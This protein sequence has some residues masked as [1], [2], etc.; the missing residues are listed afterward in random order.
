MDQLTVGKILMRVGELPALPQ[1]TYRV[2]EL[3]DN[4]NASSGDICN[5]INQ[6]H[7]L[8]SKVLKL[9][10][11]AYFGLPR[12]IAAISEAVT[13]LGMQMLRSLVIGSTV[14]QT[15]DNIPG[16]RAVAPER[17]S[18]HALASAVAGKIIASE[19]GIR[20]QEHAFTAGLLHDIG[21]IVL[22]S[23]LYREYSMVLEWAE[24]RGCPLLEAERQVLKTDHAEIGRMVAAKWNLP[25]IL[26]EAI[27]YHHDPLTAGGTGEITKIVYLADKAA[28]LAGY[29][30][31]DGDNSGIDYN[32]LYGFNFNY[33]Q[34]LNIADEIRGLIN[35]QF[36]S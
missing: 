7:V 33:S 27:G 4:P 9:V 5:E 36:L 18:R 21:I 11:S 23:L 10:N 22:S 17:S 2:I 14:L 13:I 15:L 35:I 6:D 29:G 1:V 19:V 8:A 32:V 24:T 31:I 25:P 3:T 30:T 34:L 16:R 28:W 12:K 20:E 26:V